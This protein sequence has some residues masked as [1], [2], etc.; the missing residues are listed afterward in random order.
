MSTLHTDR[1]ILRPLGESDAYAYATVRYHPAV[2]R[3]LLPADDPL[4]AARATV[5]RFAED[6][7]RDG[8]GPW[9]LFLRRKDG[10]EGRLIGHGGLRRLEEFGETELLYALHPDMWGKGY[11]SELGGA[12]LKHAFDTVGLSLVF[13]ITKPE[14]LSSQ[15]VMKRLGMSYRKNVTYKEIE[16]VWFDID[17][18]TWQAGQSG[19]PEKP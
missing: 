7:K 13:A 12:S 14:N 18:A 2:A 19:Q 1:L 6:W 9:G 11:A 5:E 16:A 10:G 17:R 8:Y 3:W 4:E 15:G